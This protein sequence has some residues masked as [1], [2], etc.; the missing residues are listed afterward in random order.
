MVWYENPYVISIL[1]LIVVG[2][3]CYVYQYGYSVRIVDGR[4]ERKFQWNYPIAFALIVWLIWNF[5]LYPKKTQT[6]PLV[7]GNVISPF[8]GIEYANQEWDYKHF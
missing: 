3:I 4:I 7:G 2:A 5:V 1:T 6:Q 8:N